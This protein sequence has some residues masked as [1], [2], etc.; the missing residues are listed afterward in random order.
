MYLEEKFRQK[1]FLATYLQEMDFTSFNK[2]N[3]KQKREYLVD[4]FRML[5]DVNKAYYEMFS[6]LSSEFDILENYLNKIFTT[7]D[8]IKSNI[9]TKKSQQE[10]KNIFRN[11]KK[12]QTKEEIEVSSENP[13][14]LLSNIE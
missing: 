10:I 14:F 6:F 2:L 7:L 1:R 13:D 5:K 9:K 4:L 11:V 8:D 12:L 3:K